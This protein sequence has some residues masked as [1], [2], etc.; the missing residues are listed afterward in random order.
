MKKMLMRIAMCGMLTTGIAALAQGKPGPGPDKAQRAARREAMQQ[1]LKAAWAAIDKD[2]CFKAMD[3]DGDG[4]ISQEEFERADLQAIIG[5]KL[6]ESMRKKHGNRKDMFKKMDKNGDGMISLEEFPRG[7]EVFEK[8][9]KKVDK[10]GDGM[11][12]LEE[13]TAMRAQ[14]GGQGH[15]KRKHEKQGGAQQQ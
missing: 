4:M 13:W 6:H 11:I 10:D 7:P 1:R 8:I 14:R 9:V 12:S 15:R 3:N 2:A 5:S